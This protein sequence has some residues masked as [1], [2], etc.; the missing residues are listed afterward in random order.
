PGDDVQ[1]ERASARVEE[2]LAPDLSGP[3]LLQPVRREHLCIDPR[4]AARPEQRL[5]RG[6][7]PVLEQRDERVRRAHE[8]RGVAAEVVALLGQRKAREMEHGERLLA[9]TAARALTG[10]T[11][12]A[13]RGAPA[14]DAG[15]PAVGQ[16]HAQAV[17]D[18]TCHA[19][20]TVITP[21]STT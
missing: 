5:Q 20:C 9:G 16:G 8:W 1:A 15:F 18:E 21:S 6:I 2:Q 13:A 11:E 7:G 17:R 12:R 10:R 4:Y 14:R 3:A 19:T